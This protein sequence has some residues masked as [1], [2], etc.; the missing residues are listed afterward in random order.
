MTLN[1]NQT[2]EMINK[3]IALSVLEE[4]DGNQTA[5]ARRLGVSRT[6]LWRMLRK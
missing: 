2:L 3:E 6:T 4:C 1:L 5:A